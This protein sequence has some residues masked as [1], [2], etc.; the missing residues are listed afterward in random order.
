V[1]YSALW[2]HYVARTSTL[3]ATAAVALSLS[4][5]LGNRAADRT[6]EIHQIQSFDTYTGQ[7]Q[8]DTSQLPLEAVKTEVK[9]DSQGTPVT[10]LTIDQKYPIRV[11]FVPATKPEASQPT[12]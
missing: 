4:G 1:S 7:F 11:V 8:I 10:L 3:V 12:K 9:N 6:L 2:K 5:C